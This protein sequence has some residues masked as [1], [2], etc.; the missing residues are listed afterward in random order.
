MCEKGEESMGDRLDLLLRFVE[1]E[2]ERKGLDAHLKA[3]KEKIVP[4]KE[5][6][7]TQVF[8]AGIPFQNITLDGMTVYLHRQLW[9][10]AKTGQ[11]EMLIEALKSAGL[12]E[13]V[14]EQFNIS[15]LSAW[16]RE[17]EREG[18]YSTIQELTESL[19]EG[20]REA[21]AVA[22]KFDLRATA[23]NK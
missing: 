3:V 10:S 9:A 7:L 6:I 5:A 4:V 16:V 20:I 14:S 1:L 19:P 12:V 21:I 22:E 11:K 15:T 2:K 18:D 17:R 8:E 13:F 23:A